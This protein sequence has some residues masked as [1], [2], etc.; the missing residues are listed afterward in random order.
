MEQLK[1]LK[2]VKVEQSYLDKVEAVRHI[3][4]KVKD[5][6]VVQKAETVK[7]TPEK[8]LQGY[9]YNMNKDDFS[10]E[11]TPSV[12]KIIEKWLEL[13]CTRMDDKVH[14]ILVQILFKIQYEVQT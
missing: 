11:V 6:E 3:P 2:R 13:I 12:L 1:F 8:L 7:A 9:T 10:I 4:E 14:P 5:G